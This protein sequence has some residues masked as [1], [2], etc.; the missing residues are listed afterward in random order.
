MDSPSN[1]RHLDADNEIVFEWSSGIEE[2]LRKEGEEAESLFWGH[3]R[4]AIVSTRY[5]D[6]IAIPSII[7]QTITGF[8]SA[9][10]GLIPPMALGAFSMFT[11]ILSTLLS[12]FKFSARSE[13]HRMVALIYLKIYKK[14][15]IELS[16][17]HEQR[18]S[19]LA[20]LEE[21]REKLSRAAEIAPDIPQNVVEE[22]K[23]KFKDGEAKKPI[24]FNGLDVIKVFKKAPAIEATPATP[25]PMIRIIP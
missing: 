24:I 23:L 17:P 11:A 18:I 1:N 14:L 19:P 22:Y 4:S 16:L 15:Q 7:I 6:W 2:V 5:N 13:A 8:F 3:Q 21:I 20:L 12:Y 25:K 10:T 9:S